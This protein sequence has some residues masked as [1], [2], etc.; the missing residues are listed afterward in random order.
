MPHK[1]FVPELNPRLQALFPTAN[2]GLSFLPSHT[3]YKKNDSL[4][5]KKIYYEIFTE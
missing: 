2:D 4:F 3:T 5:R 1:P